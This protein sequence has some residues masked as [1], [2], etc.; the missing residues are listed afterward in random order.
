MEVSCKPEDTAQRTEVSQERPCSTAPFSA[1]LIWIERPC[2]PEGGWMLDVFGLWKRS[3][4]PHDQRLAQRPCPRSLTRASVLVWDDHVP[5]QILDVHLLRSEWDYLYLCLFQGLDELAGS[6][7]KG[8]FPF[9]C[10]LGA[11]LLLNNIMGAEFRQRWVK[12][13]NGQRW[14]Q[15]QKKKKRRIR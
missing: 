12:K 6:W 2:S 11:V 7:T 5:D 8:L 4:L 14:R 10:D 9:F 15:G 13:I 1:L 3:W